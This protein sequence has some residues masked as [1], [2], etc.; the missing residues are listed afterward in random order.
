[1]SCVRFGNLIGSR[2]SVLEVFREMAQATGAVNIT[3]PEAT[4]FWI[5]PKQAAAFCLQ[6]IAEMRGSEIFVPDIGASSIAELA[7]AVAP[8]AR[9]KIVGVRQGDRMHEV[10]IM[11]NE[12]KRTHPAVEGGFIIERNTFYETLDFSYTSDNPALRLPADMLR[13][14]VEGGI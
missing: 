6:A 10:L 5:T 3:N 1:M 12:M 13:R 4:R 14:M 7:A 9:Q 11:P 2:G 8:E